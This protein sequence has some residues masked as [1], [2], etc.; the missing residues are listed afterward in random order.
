MDVFADFGTMALTI[1][2][3]PFVVA[4]DLWARARGLSP[5]RRW[6]ILGSAIALAGYG[7]ATVYGLAFLHPMDVCASPTGDGVYMDMMRDYRLDRVTVDAFPPRV[8]CVWGRVMPDGDP[9]ELLASEWGRWL[10]YAGLAL[11][12]TGVGRDRVGRDRL[13]RDGGR[14]DAGEQRGRRREVHMRRPDGHDGTLRAG[15]PA[16]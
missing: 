2:L 8:T 7:A 6:T 9:R 1:V 12:V 15:P 5:G 11:A 16:P 13:G 14:V 10:M 3:A 4:L